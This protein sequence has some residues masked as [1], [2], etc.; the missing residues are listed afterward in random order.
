VRGSRHAFLRALLPG[1]SIYERFGPSLLQRAKYRDR[2]S[3][4]ATFWCACFCVANE[5]QYYGLHQ[6]IASLRPRVATTYPDG[7]R[8]IVQ[9]A[10]GRLRM[11]VKFEF[12]DLP[13]RVRVCFNYFTCLVPFLAA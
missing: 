4:G 12:G 8:N 10:S 2:C 3:G 5:A 6:V 7:I 11:H 1:W 13:F 9:P